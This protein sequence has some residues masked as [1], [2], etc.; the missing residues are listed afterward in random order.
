MSYLDLGVV[1][2]ASLWAVAITA[3]YAKNPMNILG[4]PK[5]DERRRRFWQERTPERFMEFVSRQLG[6]NAQWVKPNEESWLKP[7]ARLSKSFV[8]IA[9]STKWKE[10]YEYRRVFMSAQIAMEMVEL[11]DRVNMELS[12]ESGKVKNQFFSDLNRGLTSLMARAQY[13][14]AAQFYLSVHEFGQHMERWRA[15]ATRWQSLSKD[16]IREK[17]NIPDEILKSLV[18]EPG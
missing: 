8:R 4:V 11:L 18:G 10:S 9:H 1:A 6:A 13:G 16:D 17:R 2:V 12:A 5:S 7:R 14:Q 3:I 15:S